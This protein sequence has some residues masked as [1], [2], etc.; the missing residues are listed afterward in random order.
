MLP[1]ITLTGMVHA[2]AKCSLDP[3]GVPKFNTIQTELQ[4]TRTYNLL[5][6]IPNKEEARIECV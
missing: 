2:R 6:L 1:R 3:Q 5:F 4:D